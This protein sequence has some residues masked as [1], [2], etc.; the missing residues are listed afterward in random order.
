M[1]TFGHEKKI[2]WLDL[3]AGKSQKYIILEKIE[4]FPE[5]VWKRTQTV[6]CAVRPEKPDPQ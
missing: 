4:Y 6:Q 3:A 5:P 2:G 1:S